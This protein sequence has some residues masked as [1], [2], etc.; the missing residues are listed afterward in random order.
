MARSGLVR[1]QDVRSILA[2][3]NCLNEL[4]DDPAIRTAHL[5]N[6]LC[7]FFNARSG[8][9]AILDSRPE[10]GQVKFSFAHAGGFLDESDVRHYQRYAGEAHLCDIL[11]TTVLESDRPVGVY[12]RR[13]CISDKAWYGSAHFN[14]MRIPLR[15]DDPIYAFWQAPVPSIIGGFGISRE[16][17]GRAF[18]AREISLTRILN[19]ALQPFYTYLYHS[20]VVEAPPRLPPR[21]Q[22][23]Y[24]QLLKG[25]SEKQIAADLEISRHTVHDHVKR[26]YATFGVNSRAELLAR[27]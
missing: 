5:M 18:S 26:I 1:E 23:V 15:I 6:E 27:R 7:R 14:E 9:L 10:G 22:A 11:L 17:R 12:P 25:R 8:I 16:L 20:Q 3:V 13:S 19:D 21:T 2:I 4:P 24:L